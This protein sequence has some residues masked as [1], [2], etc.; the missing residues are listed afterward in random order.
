MM[1]LFPDSLPEG[2]PE[3]WISVDEL[4]NALDSLEMSAHFIET[5]SDPYRWKWA[6]I[7]LHQA[8][9]GLAICAV[10]GTDS[11][12]VLEPANKKGER[13]LISVWEALNRAKDPKYLWAMATPLSLDQ[14]EHWAIDRLFNEFRNGFAHFQ[15]AGWGIE[16]AA[17][18]EVLKPASAVL[19]R[20]ALE[21]GLILY[22]DENDRTRARVALDRLDEWLDK[23]GSG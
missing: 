18:I 2:P 6:S 22:G 20:I 19:R 1:D 23:E 5:L 16:I 4:S 3:G 17:F 21:Q 12:S 15:P 9:Y 7:A 14:T 8:I 10:R 11:R 13:R